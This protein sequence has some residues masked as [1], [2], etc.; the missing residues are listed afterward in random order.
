MRWFH[1]VQ[2][3]IRILGIKRSVHKIQHGDKMGENRKRDIGQRQRNLDEGNF[4]NSVLN[5]GENPKR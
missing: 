5:S 1:D 2:Y 3:D 4:C